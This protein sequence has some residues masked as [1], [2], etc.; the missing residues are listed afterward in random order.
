MLDIIRDILDADHI[1]D[2]PQVERLAKLICS[3]TPSV[4]IRY[5]QAS[6]LAVSYTHLTLPTNTPV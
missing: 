5:D 2:D 3:E 1:V 4:G 6:L